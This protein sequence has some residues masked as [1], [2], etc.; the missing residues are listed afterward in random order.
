MCERQE[1]D[2]TKLLGLQGWKAEKVEV[3]KKEVLV[4]L[5]RIK[6]ATCSRRG[7]ISHSLYAQGKAKK[8]LHHW[9]TGRRIY[10]KVKRRRFWCK[11]CQGHF[12]KR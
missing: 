9:I 6:E 7:A 8:V 1:D 2:I 4:Y 12:L 11:A 5:D 3:S 10:V